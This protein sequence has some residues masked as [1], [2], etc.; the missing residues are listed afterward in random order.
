MVMHAYSRGCLDHYGTLDAVNGDEPNTQMARDVSGAYAYAPA[1]RPAYV[2]IANEDVE[3][4]DGAR[5][6]N[7]TSRCTA[8]ETQHSI[9]MSI[10]LVI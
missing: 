10:T 1:I 5:C 2:R 9:G 3:E 6:A 4:G 8:H 7:S